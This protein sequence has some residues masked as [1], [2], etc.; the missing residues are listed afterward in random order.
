MKLLL[1]SLMLIGVGAY[2]LF[3]QVKGRREREGYSS[4]PSAASESHEHASTVVVD[5]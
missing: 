3:K 5:E 1:P 2:A 4:V